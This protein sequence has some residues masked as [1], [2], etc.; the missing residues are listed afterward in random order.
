LN[1]HNGTEEII[2]ARL[3]GGVTYEEITFGQGSNYVSD[4]L[5]ADGL[6]LG[7]RR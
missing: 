6:S 5:D 7:A 3:K 4:I 1:Q 2:T